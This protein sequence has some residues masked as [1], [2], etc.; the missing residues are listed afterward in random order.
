MLPFLKNKSLKYKLAISHISMILIPLILLGIAELVWHEINTQYATPQETRTDDVLKQSI[1]LT[2]ELDSIIN[3]GAHDKLSDSSYLQKLNQSIDQRFFYVIVE[4]SGKIDY[5]PD[6]IDRAKLL[7]SLYD[8]KSGFTAGHHGYYLLKYRDIQF[9]DNSVGSIYL[10]APDRPKGPGIE[11][12]FFAAVL[13]GL[14]INFIISYRV[15]SNI[16]T[17]LGTL[18]KA[19]TEIARGNLDHAIEI[20]SED[21][22]GELC[23][24]YETM[25][26]QLKEA[27]TL[28]ESY[29]N[30]RKELIANISH[31]LKTPITSI[32]GYVQGLMEGVASTPEK[33]SKY[34]QTIYSNAVQMDRLIDELFLFS[35]LDLKQLVFDFEAVNIEDFLHDCV[36]DKG[37]D[38]ENKGISLSFNSIY[39]SRA[40]VWADRQRLQRVI[41]NIIVNVEQHQDP[42]KEL[43]TLEIVL[44]ENDNEAI[45]EIKDNGQGISQENLPYIFDRLYRGDPAR[46]RQ[47]KG[48]GLGLS[49]AKQIV[50]AHGGRIWARSEIDVGTSIFFT[51]KKTDAVSK[52]GNITN[53]GESD[54][55]NNINS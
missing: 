41:N 38:L 10:L 16:I 22:V 17:P 50:E 15:A 53:A 26:R 32:R 23:R 13:L 49:I 9:S 2:S 8:L 43:A 40:L 48:S 42:D 35:K 14:I 46:T 52:L 6:R 5:V 36:E 31:D 29:E 51:L 28:S 3:S 33:E 11:W 44:S 21:E 27:R 1:A 37:Y 24:S 20:P 19:T 54:D 12:I 34:I 45:I 4:K 25:R 55:E 39:P 30:N 47:S 7:S 18:N